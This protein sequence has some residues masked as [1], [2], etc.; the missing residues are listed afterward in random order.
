MT[1]LLWTQGFG[2][3]PQAKLVSF[4][5]EDVPPSNLQRSWPKSWRIFWR[6]LDGCQKYTILRQHDGG[7]ISEEVQNIILRGKLTYIYSICTSS[8]SKSP[9]L[10]FFDVWEFKILMG[11]FN[12]PLSQPLEKSKFKSTFKRIPNSRIPRKKTTHHV[13]I[14]LNFGEYVA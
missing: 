1:F 12:T 14:P 11:H 3:P 9:K 13:F 10:V 2:S 8:S 7:C 5:G 6:D 4:Q